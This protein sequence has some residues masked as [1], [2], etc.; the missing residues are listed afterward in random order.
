MK[1][2]FKDI[3]INK[4]YKSIDFTITVN[5]GKICIAS[6]VLLSVIGIGIY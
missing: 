3:V 6:I 4:K 5:Y 2:Y 1:K